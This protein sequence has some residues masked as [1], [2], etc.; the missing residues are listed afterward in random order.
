MI[1]LI[2]LPSIYSF[3]KSKLDAVSVEIG[4]KKPFFIPKACT[5]IVTCIVI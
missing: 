3:Q 5:S 4:A 1:S 2:F